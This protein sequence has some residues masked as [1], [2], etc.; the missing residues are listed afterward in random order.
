MV[1]GFRGWSDAGNVS[2]DTLQF[3]IDTLQPRTV[4]TLSGEPFVQYT[5]ERPIAQIEDGIIHELE[6]MIAELTFWTNTEGDHDV[7]FLLAREPHFNWL[8]YANGLL[9]VT[10][11]LNIQRFYAIGGVQDTISHS[12]PVLVTVVASSSATVAGVVGLEPD[13]RAAEYYGPVSIHSYLIQACAE[14]G[15]EA[16]SLWGHVPAYLQKSPKVVAKLVSILNKAVGMH[17]PTESLNQKSIEL[18]RKINEALSRDPDLKQ[19]VETIEGKDKPKTT[20]RCNDKV[21]R[22]NDFLRRDPRKNPDPQE[23]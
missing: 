23:V 5:V 20:P 13:I 22:I 10:R 17:C 8:G 14:A 3:L 19:L 15:V 2:S 4:A 16:V 6:S 21:I 18:D 7:V 9:G 12:S 11:R 1:A